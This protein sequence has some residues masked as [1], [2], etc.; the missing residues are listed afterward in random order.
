MLARVGLG[1]LEI[2][3][4]ERRVD[5]QQLPLHITPTYILY[6]LTD[7][8]TCA[9]LKLAFSSERIA[10]AG[11]GPIS[12][13]AAVHQSPIHARECGDL[14]NS[15]RVIDYTVPHVAGYN[16]LIH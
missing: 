14:I 7:R 3:N 16:Y 4:V 6:I 15:F 5:R 10:Y 1:G 2:D 8:S 13:R 12:E 9:G 11:L